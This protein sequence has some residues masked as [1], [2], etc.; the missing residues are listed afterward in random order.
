M[1]DAEPANTALFSRRLQIRPAEGEWIER[2]PIVDEAYPEAALPPSQRDGDR[3]S[4]RVRP[5]TMRYGVG[6]E[7]IKDDQ[8]S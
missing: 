8:N 2:H 5:V 7:L 1:V 4:R 3:S 6:E